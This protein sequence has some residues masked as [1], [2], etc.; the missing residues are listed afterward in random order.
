METENSHRVVARCS[1]KL[2]KKV[3]RAVRITGQKES[4][5]VRVAVEKFLAAHK[6]PKEI[7]AAVVASRIAR[8]A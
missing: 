7:M 5:L 1:E 8:C 2:K 6:T 3:E 4:E